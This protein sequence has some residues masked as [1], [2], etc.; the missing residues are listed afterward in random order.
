MSALHADATRGSSLYLRTKGAGEE[1]ALAQADL[2]VTSFRPSV[3][4][5]PSDS[6]FNRFAAL[7]KIAPGLFPLACPQARFAP[8]YVGDVADA[9]AIALTDRGTYG[10]VYDLCGPRIYSLQE[11]VEL[12]ARLI[13][14][15]TIVLGLNDFS[16]RLQARVLQYAPGKPFT[17]DN[18]LSMQTDSICAHNGMAELGIRAESVETVAPTYLP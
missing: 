8:V 17:M 1:M 10:Q 11:L 5:G 15:K 9:M 4:F 13:G 18:Y 6:F 16:S 14:A 2:Q 7:L 3:I 12:T